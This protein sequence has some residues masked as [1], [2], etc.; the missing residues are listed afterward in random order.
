MV[1]LAV[2][3]CPIAGGSTAPICGYMPAAKMARTSAVLRRLPEA[4]R[5]SVTS[6]RWISSLASCCRMPRMVCHT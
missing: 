4:H 5:T 6:L 2:A 3:C 1:G